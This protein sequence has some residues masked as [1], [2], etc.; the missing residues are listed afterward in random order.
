MPPQRARVVT[1]GSAL[2][3]M[4]G[5]LQPD[6]RRAKNVLRSRSA[7]TT[8][9]FQLLSFSFSAFPALAKPACYEGKKA[10]VLGAAGPILGNDRT[11]IQQCCVFSSS[12]R[13]LP[14]RIW[15]HTVEE[16][17]LYFGDCIVGLLELTTPRATYRPTEEPLP[18]GH[19]KNCHLQSAEASRK[20]LSRRVPGFSVT[21]RHPRWL[22]RILSSSAKI[23]LL[24]K[25][26]FAAVFALAI[27]SCLGKVS[28]WSPIET[29]SST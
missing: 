12:R 22:R 6:G 24:A 13:S 7:S 19:L 17:R 14:N 18:R 4:P 8:Q 16:V 5:L 23:T 26:V 10:V 28:S 15:V 2:T 1:G 25:E 29:H 9:S 20:P 3:R 27:A 21:H 11:K